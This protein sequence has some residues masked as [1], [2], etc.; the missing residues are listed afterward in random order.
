MCFCI[1]GCI[2]M[3]A[4][5]DPAYGRLCTASTKLLQSQ[6]ETDKSLSA[7]VM[8]SQEGD[9]AAITREVPFLRTVVK[10]ETLT[11]VTY[12]QE[13]KEKELVSSDFLQSW[14]LTENN[15]WNRPNCRK[16]CLCSTLRTWSSEHGNRWHQQPSRTVSKK[17][18]SWLFMLLHGYIKLYRSYPWIQYI[19]II[20]KHCDVHYI[21][22][23]RN[24]FR[25]Y[26]VRG[27]AVNVMK[28]HVM[29]ANNP[30]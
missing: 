30:S 9:Q 4:F 6:N 22:V 15:C 7:I 11:L 3:A 2:Y 16:N 23:Y 1:H 18:D 17:R 26:C 20:F 8:W 5:T 13:I 21:Y 27:Q 28:E 25:N 24:A 29:S 10:R 14:A 19:R 12:L